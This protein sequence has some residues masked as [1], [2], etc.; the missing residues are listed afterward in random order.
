[1]N[2]NASVYIS[3]LSV[4]QVFFFF[5]FLSNHTTIPLNFNKKGLSNLS[6]EI[7]Q[8]SA[9]EFARCNRYC[10]AFMIVCIPMWPQSNYYCLYRCPLRQGRKTC[11]LFPKKL[12][13]KSCRICTLFTILWQAV[14][15][16]IAKYKIL[17]MHYDNSIK[18]ETVQYTLL[19]VVFLPISAQADFS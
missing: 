15:Y 4:I 8:Y 9:N 11:V 5:F 12:F 19:A 3:T 18:Y 16:S 2:D 6:S 14:I 10:T 13:F 17:K 7:S 1:M